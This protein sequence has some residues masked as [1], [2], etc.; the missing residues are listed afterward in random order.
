MMLL[1]LIT[2]LNFVFPAELQS[3]A[4]AEFLE[5]KYRAVDAGAVNPWAGRDQLRH[6]ERGMA[7]VQRP[8]NDF[9]SGGD[10]LA[11][12]PQAGMQLRV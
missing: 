8:E 1:E 3:L 6:A 4:D 9:A 10:T 12:R 11:V 7:A 5:D 2:E